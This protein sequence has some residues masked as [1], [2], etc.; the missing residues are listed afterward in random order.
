MTKPKTLEQLRAEK[1]RAETQ[2]AQEKHKLNRLENRKKY[3]EK[4]ERQKRTHRLC[5]LGGIKNEAGKRQISKALS[6]N[7]EEIE[8]LKKLND[9]GIE[10]EVRMVPDDSKQDVMTLI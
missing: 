1:E 8:L 7:D 6:V 5:N 10:L 3:L 4:G 2:L 9:K